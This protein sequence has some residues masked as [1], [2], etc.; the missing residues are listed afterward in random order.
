MMSDNQEALR[1]CRARIRELQEENRFLL[2]S[3]RTFVSLAERLHEALREHCCTAT[4]DAIWMN[5]PEAV[6]L[7][8]PNPAGRGALPRP[9]IHAEFR[10]PLDDGSPGLRLTHDRP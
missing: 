9:P 2:A 5:Q 4:L 8:A 6:A 7:L 3:A 1:A 10:L